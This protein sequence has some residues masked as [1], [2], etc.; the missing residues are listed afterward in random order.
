MGCASSKRVEASVDN[1][2]P[3]PASFAAFDINS[4]QEPWLVVAETK[5]HDNYEKPTFVPTQILEKL[6]TLDSEQ[7]PHS[8]DEVS[9][10]LED[11]KPSLVQATN[12]VSVFSAAPPAK[13]SSVQP[14]S[15]KNQSHGNRNQ[16]PNK[17]LSFHTLEEF[18]AKLNSKPAKTEEAKK[19]EQQRV[20][21]APIQTIGIANPVKEN[22][23]IVRDR[24]EREKEGK[25]ANFD[26]LTST[27][28]NPLS[29]YPEKCPPG[30]NDSV[31]IYTTSLRGVRK[32]FDDCNRVRTV[33][34]GHRV[35][36]D[37]RDVALH[38]GFLSELKEVVGESSSGVPRVFVKGR[39]LGGAE[40][41]VEL[42][43][44]GMLGKML[45]HA[46]VERGIGRLGCEGCGG[47]RFVPC[48]DCGGSCRVVIDGVN[49]ER[50][51]ACN[52]N[53]LVQ[54]P[55]CL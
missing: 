7:A 36:F 22:I 38:G 25:Q 14:P 16:I 15:T 13:P 32:T 35:V 6:N 53:G 40:E 1:Y 51:S 21:E 48:L 52:E 10:A 37:E 41:V 23:F 27:R 4:V 30:G 43:E 47:A 31:V 46:K 50:C 55:L 44:S 18:D 24:L 26:R 29:Q 34:E 20:H 45:S 54:C 33:L 9:K 49:K 3:A 17:S 11:L 12:S 42:N 8:W 2:R 19:T 39:Y 5:S 28:V